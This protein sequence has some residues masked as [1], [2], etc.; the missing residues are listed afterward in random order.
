[1]VLKEKGSKVYNVN[2][3]V[4]GCINH[5]KKTHNQDDRQTDGQTDRQTERT[6]GESR[7]S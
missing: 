7:V 5:F 6:G 1:M 4:K 3:K 2:L